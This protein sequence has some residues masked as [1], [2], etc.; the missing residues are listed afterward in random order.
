MTQAVF[1]GHQLNGI[2]GKNRLSIPSDFRAAVAARSGNNVIYIGPAPG[3]DCLIG[4]DESH[5]AKIQKRL[6]DRGLDEDTPE[7]AMEATF[8]FGSVSPF[9][10]DDNG[11]IVLSATLRD[12]G[13]FTSHVWF[14]AG[15]S[16][17]QLWNP[18][19]YLELPN[20]EPRMIRTVRKEMA[21]KGLPEQEPA[22]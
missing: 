20:L 13:D 22:R 17:F 5:W 19:R 11:R 10:I 14:L 16:F 18:Y 8:R 4:Y 3:L 6:E 21:A 1:S 7:G 9:T 12:L 2:D 15:G